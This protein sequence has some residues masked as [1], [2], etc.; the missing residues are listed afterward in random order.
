MY[1]AALNLVAPGVLLRSR[2]QG[3]SGRQ[4]TS[5]LAPALGPLPPGS[6]RP[7]FL[8]SFP[9]ALAGDLLQDIVEKFPPPRSFP[10]GHPQG[11]G[12]CQ[13]VLYCNGIVTWPG[14]PPGPKS[15]GQGFPLVPLA[16][17]PRP[18]TEMCLVLTW[19]SRACPL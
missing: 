12:H 8:K 15:Q 14:P 18:G 6:P 10:A 2:M 17:K 13:V 1:S 4:V 16:P 19:G 9:V 7:S 3:T 5:P 11:L